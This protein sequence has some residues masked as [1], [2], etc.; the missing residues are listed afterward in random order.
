MAKKKTKKTGTRRRRRSA[1]EIIEDLQKQ[2]TEVKARA[3][4]K[5]LKKS[6]AVK[7]A[8]VALRAI[9][10]GMDAAQEEDNNA[11]RH[12]F[13]DAREPLASFLTEQGMKLPKSRRPKGPRPK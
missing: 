5:A 12:V 6:G 10:K 3:T 1:E 11:L 13:A 7:A 4:A 2:I 8:I 9:D